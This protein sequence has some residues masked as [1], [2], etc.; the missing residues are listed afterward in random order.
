M[1]VDNNKLISWC[2]KGVYVYVRVL[3]ERNVLTISTKE[4]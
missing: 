1:A 3:G 2:M 4:R